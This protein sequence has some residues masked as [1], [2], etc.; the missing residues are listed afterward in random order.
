VVNGFALLSET[1]YRIMVLPSHMKKWIYMPLEFLRSLVFRISFQKRRLLVKEYNNCS[2]A[3]AHFDFANKVFYACQ[4][5][6]EMCGF[7][8]HL[9]TIRPK[10]I[11]EVGV[12]RS[13]TSYL[14]CNS[15]PSVEVFVGIDFFVR[16]T[17]RLRAFTPSAVQLHAIHG[18]SNSH[19]TLDQLK[20]KLGDRKIDLLFIDGDHSYEGV[21]NDFIAYLPFLA[22][23]GQVAFHDI[24]PAHR[25]L[26]GSFANGWV[27][28]VDRFW[29]E[30]R[31]FGPHFE[32]VESSTQHAN[33]I[34]VVTISDP[35]ALLDILGKCG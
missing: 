7:L 10:V 13:G 30:L 6:S 21:R 15:S 5:K 20:N 26:D 25:E 2:S 1:L 8:G 33:G 14:L 16:N 31:R 35:L 12:A 24:L 3:E 22:Q 18:R 4:K 11:V 32:F 27:I 17:T 34:G 28:E 23:N 29:R 9:A 19:S